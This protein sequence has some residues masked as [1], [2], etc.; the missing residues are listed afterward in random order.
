M[1]APNF[2]QD[3]R[4]MPPDIPPEQLE[5]VLPVVQALLAKL[6]DHSRKLAPEAESALVFDPV[7]EPAE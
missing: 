7:L 1:L 5:R 2:R 3:S 6:K 4:C